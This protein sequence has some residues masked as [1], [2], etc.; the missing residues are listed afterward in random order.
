MR[1]TYRLHFA[2]FISLFF[3]KGVAGAQSSEASAH[4]KA[5]SVEFT[6]NYIDETTVS[7]ALKLTPSSSA[8]PSNISKV[9][10]GRLGVTDILRKGQ[11]G[12]LITISCS[13]TRT[14]FASR[15]QDA[16]AYASVFGP[17][18]TLSY[19]GVEREGADLPPQSIGSLKFQVPTLPYAL[20]SAV[21][22]VTKRTARNDLDASLHL[23]AKAQLVNL[24][25]PE[26]T[27]DGKSPFY[28]PG[29]AVYDSDGWNK[30]IVGNV[31]QPNR[32]LR[33]EGR[34]KVGPLELPKRIYQESSSLVTGEKGALLNMHVAHRFT[35]V[36]ARLGAL[37]EKDFDLESLLPNGAFIQNGKTGG[38]FEKGKGSITKQLDIPPPPA[39][40]AKN[41]SGIVM[42]ALLGVCLV[43]ILI[44]SA[45]YRSRR[46]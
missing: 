5:A 7:G 14:L 37:P 26:S 40:P 16:V 23:P 35:L 41:V 42:A 27:T 8:K 1:T 19:M 25:Y 6:A 3:L 20:P 24:L 2:V 10:L 11:P 31:S 45:W 22:A 43:G 18:S 32:L 28:A 39:Q 34:V 21:P 36:G 29:Y 12:T 46:Q 33:Y 13:R 38:A 17:K 30:Y 15:S 9:T 44:A 4:F